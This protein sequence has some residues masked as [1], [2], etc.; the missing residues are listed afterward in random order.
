MRYTQK[1]RIQMYRNYLYRVWLFN[2][3]IKFLKKREITV[4]LIKAPEIKDTVFSLFYYPNIIWSSLFYNKDNLIGLSNKGIVYQINGQNLIELINIKNIIFTTISGD[5]SN[6]FV[7]GIDLKTKQVYL[8]ISNDNGKSWI[9][10]YQTIIDQY[11]TES[12]INNN[13]IMVTTY[14]QNKYISYDKGNLWTNHEITETVQSKLL[15]QY[16]QYNSIYK[17]DNYLL[18]ISLLTGIFK[19]I[20]NGKTWTIIK[21]NKSIQK[22]LSITSNKNGTKITVQ[23]I[24]NNNMIGLLNIS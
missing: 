12:Y 3:Y 15:E 23:I 1:Q 4:P 11:C 9:Q 2:Q 19:S 22:Y 20:D 24:D 7:S 17:N 6:I 21:H 14:K 13:T 18:A 8:L 16:P 10:I 5:N